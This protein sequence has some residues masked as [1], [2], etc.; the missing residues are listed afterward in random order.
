[1]SSEMSSA[2]ESGPSPSP[3]ASA[4]TSIFRGPAFWTGFS[5]LAGVALVFAIRFFPAAF[6]VVGLEL[7]MDRESALQAAWTLVEEHE[8]VP[9]GYRQAASF[10]EPNREARTYLE[11]ELGVEDAFQH[12]VEVAD[13]HPYRWQVR[14]FR[15][16]ER[17]EVSVRFAPDGA[18]YGFTLDLPEDEPGAALS[19]EE[20]RGLAEAGAGTW[21]VE[22]ER[23]ELV[24]SSQETRSGGRV[25]HTFVYR[26]QGVELGD[27]EARLRLRVA[28]DRPSEVGRLIRVPESFSRS[29]DEL[30]SANETVALAA[31]LVFLLLFGLAG[32]GGG[33]FYLIRREA[34]IWR[35]ALAWGLL[36]AGLTGLTVLS[37]LP[38]AWMGYDTA[39]SG[40]LFLTQQWVT[41]LGVFLGGG[42]MLAIIFAAAEG[43]TRRAM[44]AE[45]RLWNL[46]SPGVANTRAVLGRTLGGYLLAALEVGF[47]VAFYLFAM[48]RE[49]WWVPS[50]ALVQ[51]DLVA[52]YLPSLTAISGSLM[53][54]FWEEALFRAVPLA[55]A[56]LIGRRFGWKGIL[57]AF[58]LVLQALVFAAAHADYPQQPAYARVLELVV[59]ATLWGLVY[60]RFGLLPVILA[61]AL[62][63]LTW[64]SLPIFAAPAGLWLDRGLLVAAALLPLA[65]ILYRIRQHGL[66]DEV[67]PAGLNQ[68][69][70]L[71]KPR[72]ADMTDE[73][74]P[75]RDTDTTAAGVGGDPEEDV[76]QPSEGTGGLA[77]TGD[78]GP[79]GRDDAPPDGSDRDAGVVLQEPLSP[80]AR[81][82]IRMG[83][84]VAGGLGAVLWLAL[85][86]LQ[87]D[88]P[89]LAVDRE[90]AVETARERLA[91]EGVVLEDTWRPLPRIQGGPGGAHRFVWR[92]GGP[93]AHQVLLEEGHLRGPSWNVRFVRFTGTVEER[94]EEFRV[95]IG[96]GGQVFRRQHIVPEDRPGAEL[97]E[98]AARTRVME[99]VE[100][101][102]GL[103][104]AALEDV[105]AE[106]SRKPARVDWTFTFSRPG[107]HPMEE[108]EARV[109]VGLVGDRP[110]D[111]VRFVHVPE[112]WQRD[113]RERMTRSNLLGMVSVLMLVTLLGGAAVVG[114]IRWARGR[115]GFATGAFWG[116]G[117]LVL[118]ASAFSEWLRWP[119]TVGGFGTAQPYRDQVFVELGV[120]AMGLPVM[121]L[122]AGLVAG[123][124]HGGWRQARSGTSMGWPSVLG[125]GGLL[126]L[127]LAGASALGSV[128]FPRQDPLWFGASP[129]S[130]RWPW[131]GTSPE[132]V[133]GLVFQALLVLLVILILGR[134]TRGWRSERLRGVGVAVAGGLALAGGLSGLGVVPW[135]LGAA[136][137]AGGFALLVPITR[138]L[139]V[140]VIPV[141]V[142]VP[143]VLPS[144]RDGLGSAY[145]GALTAG[146]ITSVMV[147]AVA[148]GWG[149][150]LR[151]GGG[152]GPDG[153]PEPGA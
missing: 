38:L 5:L 4:R 46:W 65:V 93:E 51:P 56:I 151:G 43:L 126:G 149:L 21:G 142:A 106:A 3:E 122:A 35:P 14:H 70:G 134:L 140:A 136:A 78:E 29:W 49:G 141:M 81:R 64:F 85:T 148:T 89:T 82:R 20:A 114:L 54:G 130:F 117:A 97:E 50:E 123:V 146:L 133:S 152:T 107:I 47:V 27:A 135:L 125:W 17:T 40:G 74:P 138:A 109:E 100:T 45:P 73:V 79:R 41:A 139:H 53:A 76:G 88:V 69:A 129:A 6:P 58:A 22:L 62:Y 16:G 145:P 31:G 42:L 52:T 112:E 80:A 98:E 153:G 15:E 30:R 39:V 36:V 18:P 124:I 2:P 132:A 55:V 59:P 33:I 108:G 91:D 60:L 11:L 90:E 96:P 44:P 143:A 87:P 1:M 104:P 86:P 137:G 23:Y 19:A 121:A 61:H 101:V 127:A 77:E 110:S 32:C 84:G 13:Y 116:L 147:L 7:A 67:S 37:G 68:G 71:G 26:M 111:G 8:W 119:V 25:D 24:E 57:V 72:R 92:E 48:R 10:R 118:G 83:V 66:A 94:A 103:D 150:V 28:G 9:D 128:L 120:M 131:M 115:G 144:L 102:L 99:E 63:N 75:H 105:S 34:L 12:L 95:G 113:E